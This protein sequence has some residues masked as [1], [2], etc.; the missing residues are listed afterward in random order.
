MSTTIDQW[1]SA[2][3]QFDG[4]LPTTARK[5]GLGFPTEGNSSLYDFITALLLIYSNIT[6]ILLLR[7]GIEANPGP[8]DKNVSGRSISQ[9]KARVVG[10]TYR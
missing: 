9:R 6:A 4:G 3:G 5:S 7:A 1:R 2:I 10:I 8:V